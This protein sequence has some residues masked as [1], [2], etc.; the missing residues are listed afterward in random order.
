VNLGGFAFYFVHL[1]CLL[2]AQ[3]VAAAV[4]TATA[5]NQNRV[6]MT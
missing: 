2:I 5:T 1:L 3:I 6:R 4:T